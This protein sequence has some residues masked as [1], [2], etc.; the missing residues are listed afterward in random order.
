MVNIMY[1]INYF[2]I[3]SILG[4]F[5]E[6]FFYSNGDSGILLGYWTPIYGIGTI[7]ILLI[8]KYIDRFKLN[9][10]LK[11]FVLFLSCSIVLALMEALGGYLIKW[12]FN[13]ELWDYSNHRFNI[14]KY[15][16]LEMSLLWGLSSILL[17]YFIKP[18]IDKIISKIPKY[19]TYILI[20][21]FI[22][23]CLSTII[24]KS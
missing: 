20:I 12:I 5:M 13:K 18:F 19:L 7:I 17:I 21:L 24:I 11:V 3:M 8:H 14:G 16:S 15:T 1:Y 22:I 2:F 10:I 4:H 9:K 6:S 23:D